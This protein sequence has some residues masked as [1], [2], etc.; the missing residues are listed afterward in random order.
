MTGLDLPARRLHAGRASDTAEI[1]A[2]MRACDARLPDGQRLVGDPYA[3]H[4]VRRPLYRVLCGTPL[5]ARWAL[6]GFDLRYPGFLAEIL[7]R[8]R[9][10]DDALRLA[11]SGGIGQVVM[12]GAGYDATALRQEPGTGQ[13]IF[14]VDHPSTQRAKLRALSGLPR[15]G[16]RAAAYVPCDLENGSLTPALRAAGFDPGQPCLIGWLG[17]SYYLRMPSFRATLGEIATACAPGSRLILDYLDEDVV[18]GTSRHA[19]AR[20]AT[21]AVAR[22]GEPYTLGLSPASVAGAAEPHGFRLVESIR[23]P[24]LVGRYGGRRPWVRGDDFMGVITLRR[25]A[26]I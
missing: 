19:G 10:F 20:R 3:R 7:L 13:R 24:D 17:V 25:E 1:N 21:R 23:V 16:A 6:R 14:E 11:R 26:R 8:A 9:Y 18:D 22:R 2:A 4:F 15:G 12:L 5:L